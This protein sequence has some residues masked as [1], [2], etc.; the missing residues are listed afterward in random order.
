MNLKTIEYESD[1]DTNC[2]WCSRNGQQRI[3]TRTGGRSNQGASIDHPNYNIY[4]IGLNS[5][6]SP[7]DLRRPDVTHTHKII[8]VNASYKTNTH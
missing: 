7:E 4:K 1:S 3:G 5:E 2:N 6:K 8:L